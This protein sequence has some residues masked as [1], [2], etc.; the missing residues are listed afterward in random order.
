MT[1]FHGEPTQILESRYLQ[2][3][4]LVNSARIVRFSPRGKPNLF[5]DLGHSAIQTP[6]GS[7]YFRGGHR[8]WHAPEAMPR[9]YMPDNDGA[10]VRDIPT[11]MRIEMPSESWTHITKTIEIQLNPD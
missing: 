2:L 3:E 5:A 11:G 4:Y 9:T 10:V 7:F 1:D 8:L 6:F